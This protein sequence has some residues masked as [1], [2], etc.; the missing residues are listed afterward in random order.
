MD[1]EKDYIIHRSFLNA[2]QDEATKEASKFQ[3]MVKAFKRGAKDSK[4]GTAIRD[5]KR[6]TKVTKSKEAGKTKFPKLQRVWKKIKADW[7]QG[8]RGV[9]MEAADPAVSMAYK[10]GKNVDKGVGATA[11]VA[12]LNKK[13]KGKKSDK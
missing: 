4:T 12:F 7:R 9:K 6:G 8:A 11:A 10:M 2:L 1:N 13:L 3:K 5:Y